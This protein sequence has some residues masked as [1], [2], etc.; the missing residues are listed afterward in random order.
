[1]HVGV[2]GDLPSNRRAV[3]PHVVPIGMKALVHP[4]LDVF[5]E[6]EGRGDLFGRQV[7]DGFRVSEGND[8][9]SP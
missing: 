9:L 4:R 6:C 5:E 7:E 2:H 3:P 8:G 1:M